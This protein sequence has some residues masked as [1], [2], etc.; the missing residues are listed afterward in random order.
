MSGWAEQF[1][2]EEGLSFD[3]V[4]DADRVD[5]NT[6]TYKPMEF[7]KDFY[8]STVEFPCR[9]AP[10]ADG[11]TLTGIMKGLKLCFLYP[12]NEGLILRYQFNALVR[13][14][15]AD[16]ESWTGLRVPRSPPHVVEIPH[17][18]GSKVHFAHA[19]NIETFRQALQGM[20][21]GWILIEQGDDFPDAGVFDMLAGRFRRILT[22]IKSIQQH[23]VRRKIIKKPVKD[24]RRLIDPLSPAEADELQD[25]I[26]SAIRAYG[27]PVRQIM[28]IANACGHNWIWKRWINPKTRITREDG[29]SYSEGE[30]FENIKYVPRSTRKVWDKM[31]KTAPKKYRRYVLNSHE[32]FDIEGAYYA[33]LMSDAL[34][35]GRC[36]IDNLYDE[37]APVYT[38]WDLGVRGQDSTSIVFAQ[39]GNFGIKVIDF[40]GFS[41]KGM[42][43]YSQVLDEKGYSYAAHYLP[44]DSKSLVQAATAETRLAILRN[45]RRRK[46]EDI[47]ATDRLSLADTHECVRHTIPKCRFDNKT[48][49]LVEA[50]MQY[51]REVNKAKSTEEEQVFVDHPAKDKY[52]HPA[53]AFGQL[54]QVYRYHPIDGQVLGSSEAVPEYYENEVYSQGVTDLLEVS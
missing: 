21:L 31:K 46:G 18:G 6:M 54:G 48:E 33:E 26:E 51:H 37:T 36:E 4:L 47:L 29:Y 43:H 17:S 1:A 44:H 13:S 5:E 10:W 12:G 38:F 49:V 32:A 45:L 19:D 3:P 52:S 24:F 8:Q 30:P 9:V 50:L 40:Y 14:T 35:E 41:G 20:N 23:L 7:Q 16:F 15:M 11:K 42:A 27:Y 2:S 22:P 25:K 28:V 53:D 34:E 39:F